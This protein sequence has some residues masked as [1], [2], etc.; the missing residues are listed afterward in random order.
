MKTSN[1]VPI[2]AED[3]HEAGAQL[4][5]LAKPLLVSHISPDGDALGCLIGMRA[6]LRYLGRNPVAVLFEPCPPRYAS[7]DGIADLHVRSGPD[8][9]VLA[10]ADGV[11]IMDTC[12]YSQLAPVADWLRRATVPKIVL[13]H[14]TT[15]DELA[16]LYLIDSRMAASALIVYRWAELLGWSIP[17]EAARAIFVGIA[18]DTGWFR[19]SNTTAE[20]LR[21][22]ADLVEGGVDV[23]AS[24][25]SLY[26]NEPASRLRFRAAAMGCLELLEG[27]SLAVM[28]V[29][30]QMLAAARATTADTEEA[31]NIPMSVASVELSVLLV[32]A[33]E[34]EV[35]CSFRSKG[36]IDVARL[37]AGFGG[38]GHAR[39]AGARVKGTMD[40][41]KKAVLE[42]L[43][44]M[45]S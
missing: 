13:D 6:I 19:F 43:E 45:R 41:V 16:D 26:L 28:A 7:M 14:H 31:V 2:T 22:A 9:P 18:T 21:V 5:S 10:E 30:P 27:D 11:L 32:D 23:D 25:A 40:S 15:R 4:L 36:R 12:A 1:D 38:G 24:Y 34:G 33:G 17:A 8:D 44:Q 35:N 39:A 37:A 3:Y 20:A 42:R 29:T